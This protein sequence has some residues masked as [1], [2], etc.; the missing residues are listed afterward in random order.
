MTASTSSVP[1]PDSSRFWPADLY[2]PGANP[3]SF[4]KQYVRD[5]LESIGWNKKP[6]APKL[7][8]EVIA[9]TAEKYREA[10]TRLTGGE[11]AARSVR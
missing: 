9:K 10:L 11:T 6:P 3:P 5:Y 2:K 7:P 1:A 4:D 8:P